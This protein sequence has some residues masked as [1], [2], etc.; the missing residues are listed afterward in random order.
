MRNPVPIIY[1]DPDSLKPRVPHAPHGRTK[2][3]L[4][5]RSLLASSQ[6]QPRPAVAQVRGRHRHPMGPWLAISA[7]GG[8]AALL[9]VYGPAGQP[10]SRPRE[11]LDA[12]AQVLRQPR[13]FASDEALRQWGQPTPH[14]DVHD[15]TLET[16]VRPRFQTKRKVPRPRHPK[17]AS[18]QRRIPGHVARATAPRHPT[19]AEP[20]GARVPSGRQAAWLPDRAPP[21]P[22]GGWEP[23]R[24]HAPACRCVVRCRRRGRAGHG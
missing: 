13:G 23:T 10:R 19:A 9:A 16:I 7:T 15:Q 22:H 11:V 14:R 1:E 5:R 21:P 17:N 4:H 18:G 24:R 8:L 20:A 6:A 2:P 12:L 3:R